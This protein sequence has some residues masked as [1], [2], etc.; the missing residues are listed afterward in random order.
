MI[1]IK[2][3]SYEAYEDVT[4]DLTSRWAELVTEFEGGLLEVNVSRNVILKTG[5][6]NIRLD[7]GGRKAWIA[8]EDFI[9][10]IIK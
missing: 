2:G 8:F 3:L 9:E 6:G 1:I 5:I 10:V 7:L 4:A